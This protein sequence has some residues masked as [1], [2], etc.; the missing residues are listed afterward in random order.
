MKLLYQASPIV[1]HQDSTAQIMGEFTIC[2]LLVFSFGCYYYWTIDPNYAIRAILLLLNACITAVVVELI[3]AKFYLKTKPMKYVY[4]SFPWVSAI[5]LVLMCPVAI[6]YYAITIG[7]IFAIVVGKLLFGGFGKNIFNP[8]ALGRAII[9]TSFMGSISNDIIIG[10]TPTTT[11]ASY[12][13]LIVNPEIYQSF[14]SKFGGL[15]NL[16]IGLYP[17]A[18]GETST[19]LILL[20]GAYLIYRNIIDWRIPVFF[21]GGVFVLSSIVAITQGMGIW[22]PIFQI[23]TGGLAFGAVFMATDPVTNPTANPGRIIFA[24][25]LAL[26][27]VLIR[28]QGNYPEGVLFAILIMNMLTSFIERATKGKQWVIVKKNVWIMTGLFIISCLLVFGISLNMKPIE[29]ETKATSQFRQANEVNDT[30][31][32][33]YLIV[34]NYYNIKGES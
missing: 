33:T 7:T 6:S 28:L 1:R 18:L 8:A 26:V 25:G 9:F 5:I 2:L 19:L 20:C 17:G 10:A 3:W 34:K 27:T 29:L 30:S 4:Y 11:I 13:W 31:E 16:F 21:L 32:V 22:Y 14:M 23:C 15:S 24:L 12:N